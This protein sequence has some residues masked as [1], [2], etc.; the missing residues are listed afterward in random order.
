[1]ETKPRHLATVI[2]S[3]LFMLVCAFPFVGLIWENDDAAAIDGEG[4]DAIP[5]AVSEE[6]EFNEYYFNDLGIYFEDNFAYRNNCI[7]LNARVRAALFA[8]SATDQV[9]IGENGWMYYGGTLSDFLASDPMTER[10]AFNIAHNSSLMQGYARAQGSEFVFVIAPNKNALY[11]ENMPYYYLDGQNASMA[12]L[13]SKLQEKD[14]NYVNL[15]ELFEEQE[16]EL[17]YLTDSHWNTEGALLVANALLDSVGKESIADPVNSEQTIITGDIEKM[18]FPVTASSEVS[19]RFLGK[20]W[21]FEAGSLSV[22]DASIDTGSN[23]DGALLMYRDSFANNLIPW[24]A[25]EFKKAH[26]SKMVPYDLTQINRLNP[27]VVIVERAQ[28]HVSLLAQSPP[29]MPPPKTA[30]A[31]AEVK[32]SDST[33]SWYVDGGFIA[34]EGWV[35]ESIMEGDSEILVQIQAPGL[36]G[37]VYVPFYLSKDDSDNVANVANCPDNAS[38]YGFRLLFDSAMLTEAEYSIT[39]LVV[40]EENRKAYAVCEADMQR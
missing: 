20:P 27:D 29:Y 31:D 33:V 18:L 24:L 13:R 9:I 22:E 6:G 2:F 11:P 34:V 39:V 14:V 23:G 1:M 3:M 37:S 15:F 4:V 5:K 17:Y 40:D 12:L 35:D 38:D 30:V 32:T 16:S 25:P 28:R 19:K 10:E 36:E 26:F 7:D 8:T 21:S